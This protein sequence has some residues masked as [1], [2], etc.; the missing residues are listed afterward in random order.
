MIPRVSIAIG[1]EGMPESAAILQE[2]NDLPASPD[3]DEEI[4]KMLVFLGV[5]WQTRAAR[6]KEYQRIY[7]GRRGRKQ[8]KNVTDDKAAEPTSEHHARSAGDA[9]DRGSADLVAD[10][11]RGGAGSGE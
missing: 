8:K 5:M 7:G 1:L 10:S 6:E 2:I 3:K 9:S 11:D 4:G